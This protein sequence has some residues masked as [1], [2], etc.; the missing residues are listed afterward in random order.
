MWNTTL[1]TLHFITGAWSEPS[2]N[3]LHPVFENFFYVTPPSQRDG[4]DADDVIASP[5]STSVFY[6][7]IID[8]TL[9]LQY[10]Q[11]LLNSTKQITSFSLYLFYCLSYNA[12]HQRYMRQPRNSSNYYDFYTFIA[13]DINSSVNQGWSLK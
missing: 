13:P 2:N 3:L 7:P 9:G 8:S 5:E 11:Q 12:S 6:Y 10:G 4:N 1:S